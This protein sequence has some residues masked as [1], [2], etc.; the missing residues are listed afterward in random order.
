LERELNEAVILI[1][2]VSIKPSA[3]WCTK[4]ARWVWICFIIGNR[5]WRSRPSRFRRPLQ[6]FGGRVRIHRWTGRVSSELLKPGMTN[7]PRRRIRLACAFLLLRAAP[8]LAECFQRVTNVARN[9]LQRSRS[10]MTGA[11]Y[12]SIWPMKVSS[13]AV[14]LGSWSTH[15]TDMS[16]SRESSISNARTPFLDS[17][18][19]T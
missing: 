11:R 5:A 1:S 16:V 9:P 4:C 6:H 2:T 15:S 3:I 19:S 8:L 17:N 18:C 14:A 12:S 13:R 7:W 10:P